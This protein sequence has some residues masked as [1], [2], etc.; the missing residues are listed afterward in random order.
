L[1]VVGILFIAMYIVSGLLTATLAPRV[2]PNA[3]FG[4]RTSVTL[5]DR[6]IWDPANQVGGW[7]LVACGVGL[8]PIVILVA[9]LDV[10]EGAARWLVLG[11]VV[12]TLL[13]LGIWAVVYPPRLQK[14]LGGA[15]VTPTRRG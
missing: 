12:A 11:Y 15:P 6:R 14:A 4:V 10:D 2:G 8:V 9:V 3:F 7:I 1:L 13:V 5:S